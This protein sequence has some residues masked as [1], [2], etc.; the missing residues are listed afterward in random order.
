MWVPGMEL[1]SDLTAS[2]F[3]T[4]LALWPLMGHLVSGL[5]I[6]DGLVDITRKSS[7]LW[8]EEAPLTADVF[9]L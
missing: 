4:E 6:I 9:L 3:P 7:V 1:M 5:V 2:T 8:L